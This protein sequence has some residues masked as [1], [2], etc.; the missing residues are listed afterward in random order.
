MRRTGDERK[1]ERIEQAEERFRQ[2]RLGVKNAIVE[3]DV[4]RRRLRDARAS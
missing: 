4:A 3:L 1:S 2:A